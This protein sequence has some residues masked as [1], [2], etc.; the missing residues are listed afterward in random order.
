MIC[1]FLA[2]TTEFFQS[3][4]KF[5]MEISRTCY[6]PSCAH[7][8]P[9][10]SSHSLALSRTRE[11]EPI[12]MFQIESSAKQQISIYNLSQKRASAQ[13]RMEQHNLATDGGYGGA[14]IFGNDVRHNSKLITIKVCCQNGRKC[15]AIFESNELRL[16]I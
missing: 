6:Q 2:V 8:F 4:M 13:I 12:S 1:K 11:Q 7:C 15:N 16:S 10:S 3:E 14:Q 9:Q 5:S